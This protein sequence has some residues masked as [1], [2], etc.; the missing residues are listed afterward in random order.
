MKD[1]C[2]N[3]ARSGDR[4][5]E[6]LNNVSISFCA[7]CQVEALLI[8]HLIITLCKLALDMLWSVLY[9]ESAFLNSQFTQQ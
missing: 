8:S 6:N 7:L 5:M 4:Y 3:T 2:I 1:K 9:L